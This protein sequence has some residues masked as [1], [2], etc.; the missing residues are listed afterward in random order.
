MLVALQLHTR[1]AEGIDNALE[2][3]ETKLD[4]DQPFCEN[5]FERKE[6]T[7]TKIVTTAANKETRRR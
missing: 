4:E 3:C 1:V 2:L 7:T 5:Q 6:A